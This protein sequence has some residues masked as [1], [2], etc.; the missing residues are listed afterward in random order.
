MMFE[1]VYIGKGEVE[2]IEGMLAEMR[3]TAVFWYP[4]TDFR[5]INK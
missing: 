3:L 1:E 2:V 5:I 4:L